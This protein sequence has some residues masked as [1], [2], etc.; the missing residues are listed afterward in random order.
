[1]VADVSGELG[2]RRPPVT[3][4]VDLPI[5]PMLWCGRH[6][7]LVLPRPL[8]AQ[9]DAIGRRAVICHELAHLRRR[10]H[11]VCRTELI[12]GWLY[13]WNP[14]V[15]WVR[16]QLRDEADLSCDAWVTALIPHGRRAY[17][18]ALLEARRCA[19]ADLSAVPS[20]GLGAT[21]RRA[22]RF[23]R[24]LT[25]VMT[26]HNS[27][28]LSRKGFVLTGTLML[29][30]LLVTP[31]WAC[32]ESEK[33]A[34]APKTHECTDAKKAKKAETTLEIIVP[35]RPP[36][37]PKPPAAQPTT[38]ESFMYQQGHGEDLEGRIRKLEQK[39]NQLTEELKKVMH[40][41][42][43]GGHA[44]APVAAPPPKV[45]VYGGVSGPPKVQ[46]TGEL[47]VRS[48]KLP[49][50][51]L[52]A[53]TDLMVLQDVPIL[54]RPGDSEIE[55]HAIPEHQMIFEAF[56]AM[57]NGED[58]VVGYALSGDKLK[59][60]NELMVRSDVPIIVEPGSEEI[61]V[62]GTH[63]EQL[64]FRAFVNMIEP[65]AKGMKAPQAARGDAAQAYARALADLA[66]QYETSAAAQMAELEG[67]RAAMRSMEQQA[68]AVE[69]QADKLE[70]EADKYWD[71][72]E[73]LEDEAEEL[74]EEAEAFQGNKRN[75]MLV[76]AEALTK[77]AEVLRA[78]A[79]AI[80]AQVEALEAQA[81]ELEAQAE[82][83]E[84]EIEEL[85]E[86]EEGN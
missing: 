18:Q 44:Q 15:W 26:A 69:R 52:G 60:L 7:R 31:I 10:D 77:K 53:L 11:W 47:V 51:K 72:A 41:M 4:M 34:R 12:I 6:V 1:M 75:E 25:M 27:P 38:F 23:A 3:L 56:C 79:E 33:E 17:A 85:E 35:A 48:Y 82:N 73:Q 63:L 50:G 20:V 42:Q 40:E 61:R 36:R 59:A 54:V 64:V 21:T 86:L 22:R 32:P 37:A 76:K 83:I 58:E 24:R 30:G 19:S 5:A 70:R 55:V 65:G 16:R 80:E 2:L 14:V 68:K 49:K 67:L 39:L 62:H 28:R 71:K 78:Q 8:W 45:K 43:Q 81:A 46:D 84:D 13:W 9:L 57:I 29:G 66:H 74:L